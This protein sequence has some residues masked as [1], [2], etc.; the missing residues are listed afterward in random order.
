M[1][2]LVLGGGR[3]GKAAIYDLVGSPEVKRLLCADAELDAL[4]AFLA[5]LGT[6]KASAVQLDASDTAALRSLMND[7]IDVVVDLL[8]RQFAP[9][10]AQAAIDAGV[11]LVNTNYDHD[12]RD[13]AAKAQQANV[14][15]LPEMGFDPGIDLVLAGEAVRHLDEVHALISYGGGVPE[16]S[17]SHDNPLRYK[18]TWTWEGVLHSYHRTAR[19]IREGQII[20]IPADKLFEPEHGRVIEL[21]ELGELEAFPNGDASVYAE[22]LGI[23]RTVRTVARYALRWPGHRAFWQ[24]MVQLGFLDETPVPGL[25]TEVTPRQFMVHHLEPRLRY[26]PEQRDLAI[27]RVDVEGLAGGRRQRRVIDLIDAKDTTAQ[28]TAMSRTVGF[29]ASIGAQMLARGTIADRGL[30]SPAVHV[31][32]EPFV[33]EL[34]RRGI[35][36]GERIVDLDRDQEVTPCY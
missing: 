21:P 33:H 36:A 9:S 26:E 29:T 28:L 1:N 15:L 13:L 10:V 27:I 23:E 16:P 34:H 22:K 5:P 24:A 17:A 14:A 32:Y 11:H 6:P 30:L 25:P 31:P 20:T 7:A 2:V 12:L 18:I 19:Q 35:R 4:R 3:Q 8:P